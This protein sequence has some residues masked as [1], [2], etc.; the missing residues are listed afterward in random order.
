MKLSYTPI[1]YSSSPITQNGVTSSIKD[2]AEES[3][4]SGFAERLVK[5]YNAQ[6]I[7]LSMNLKSIFAPHSSKFPAWLNLA[8]GYGAQDMLGAYGNA[9]RRNDVVFQ[10]GNSYTR[11]RQLFISFDIDLGRLPV[12][13]KIL[14]GLCKVLNI[15]KIPS[16]TMEFNT[17]GEPVFHFLY[18]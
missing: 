15:I 2:R 1:R 16:P 17:R 6:T 11:Y 5:D 10:P 3:F 14:R 12:Q 4:G 7:W 9:W 8:V 18:F 13:N